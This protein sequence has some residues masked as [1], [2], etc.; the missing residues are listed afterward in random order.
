MSEEIWKPIPGFN[1]WYEASSLGRIRSKPRVIH[2]S[3][4]NKQHRKGAILKPGTNKGYKM[5]VLCADGKRK[6]VTVHSLIA[7]AFLGPREPGIHVRH[8]DGTRDNNKVSNLEYGTRSENTLDSVEHGTHNRARVTHCPRGHA[9]VDGNMC[10]GKLKR[11]TRRCRSC[12]NAWAYLK[13]K[14]MLNESNL[15][16]YSDQYYI[17][18]GFQLSTSW[19][20]KMT[21]AQ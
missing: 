19:E 3:N 7:L 6:T 12:N 2:Q 8:K 15:K 20:A 4:G 13:S 5:V 10:L 11:G 9:Y 21:T 16:E 14:D 17:G 18:F 1:D